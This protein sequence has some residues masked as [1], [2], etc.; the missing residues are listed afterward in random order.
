MQVYIINQV[1]LLIEISLPVI[2][3]LVKGL[4]KISSYR[5][6]DWLRFM[7]I[8]IKTYLLFLL[9][10]LKHEQRNVLL[11]NYNPNFW[12]PNLITILKELCFNWFKNFSSTR[13]IIKSATFRFLRIS[14][15]VIPLD[16]LSLF[17]EYRY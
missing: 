3:Q 16:E 13:R 1:F 17:V 14:Y 15:K 6:S 2:Q 7:N 8:S 11:R 4:M 12:T 5:I 9:N 10:W